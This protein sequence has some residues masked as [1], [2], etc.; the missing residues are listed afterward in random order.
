M[1]VLLVAINAKYIHSNLAVYNLKAYAEK[2]GGLDNTTIEIVE[3]TINQLQDEILQDIYEKRADI[4]AFSCYIWN[5]MFVKELMVDLKKVLP[6]SKIWLGGPEVSY[7]ARELLGQQPIVTGI[8]CGE[9]EETFAEVLESY[10]GKRSLPDVAGITFYQNYGVESEIVENPWREMIDMNRIPFIYDDVEAFEHK[11][12]YYESSRGCP[13]SCSYCLSS[14]DKKLRFR[15]EERVKQE[16]Q[17]FLNHRVKQVKFVDR[18]FNCK[19]RNALGIWSYIRDNDNGVTNFHFE[20]AADL[21]TE[22]EMEVLASMRS[23][24]VQLEIGVQTTNERTVREI[25]RTMNLNQVRK[26]V[27]QVRASNRVHQHLDL[28]AGLPYEGYETFQ[29]SFNE[30]YEMKP[31]QLQLGFLK[32]LKG[33]YMEEMKEVYGLQYKSAPPYEVLSTNWLSYEEVIRL[34]V[35]EEM[36]ETYYN[37]DQFSTTMELL[38][39][40]FDTPFHLYEKLSTFYIRNDYGKQKCSRIAR[41]EI[42]YDFIIEELDLTAEQIE[43]F[44]DTLMMDLCLREACKVRPRFTRNRELDKE[45][46]KKFFETEEKEHKVLKGYEKYDKRQMSKMTHVEIIGG[47]HVLFDY[48]N[49]DPLTHGARVYEL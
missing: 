39:R 16:I 27:L 46:V 29:T 12:I 1:K 19:Q 6:N 7:C 37:S 38:V 31:A 47:E 18:T 32:V 43:K 44:Y 15:S 22:E 49:R 10:E 36:V 17:I 42:L 30:V 24:L 5:I 20:V 8:M 23:G 34:K 3:Y 33:S 4:V 45:K 11:I 41:Y 48:M 40:E 28:I 25:K 26:N 35:I 14:I 21:L 9:G 2:Y 13:F